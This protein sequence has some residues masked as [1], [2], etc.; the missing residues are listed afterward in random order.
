ME[1]QF[2]DRSAI[3]DFVMNIDMYRSHYHDD[4]GKWF[5]DRW[6][7]DGHLHSS[8]IE[9]G[10]IIFDMSGEYTKTDK[11]NVI[12]I[13]S[14]MR[15][16]PRSVA[17]D[18]RMWSALAHTIGWDFVQY[19]RR[20]EI[21]M[22]D[23]QRLKTIFFFSAGT[24]RSCYLQ[25]L[26]KYWWCGQ[27]VFDPTNRNDPYEALDTMCSQRYF[28]S[29]VLFIASSNFSANKNVLLGIIDAFAWLQANRIPTKVDDWKRI[30]IYLNML[31]STVVLDALTREDVC[32][33]CKRKL[34]KTL[35]LN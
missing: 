30:L 25:A 26:A 3:D 23:S 10:D 32:D 4:S 34:V 7:K 13:H 15:N 29:L 28:T 14:A 35:H 21:A 33:I 17:A 27:L 22:D 24:R 2:L 1:L 20:D 6:K 19:R 16:I 12:A 8:G 18:E 5:C 31:G 11:N 9:I